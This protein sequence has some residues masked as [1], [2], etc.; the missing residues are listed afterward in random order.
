MDDAIIMFK[1]E[2]CL[3]CYPEP[4]QCHERPTIR[5]ECREGDCRKPPMRPN[6]ELKTR[7]PRW[8]VDARNQAQAGRE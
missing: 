6:G 4:R 7:E 5:C 1:C 2:I 8:W 3:N